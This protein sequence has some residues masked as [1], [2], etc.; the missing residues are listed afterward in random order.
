MGVDVEGL[1]RGFA[2]GTGAAGEM[3]REGREEV[4]AAGTNDAEGI[5]NEAIMDQIS[6]SQCKSH[7]VKM[8]DEQT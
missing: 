2:A 6:L 1:V 5:D 4:S 7:R 8:T 3:G